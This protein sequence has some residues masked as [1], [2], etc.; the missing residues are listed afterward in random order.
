M[1]VL[2]VKELM[3]RHSL[4]WVLVPFVATV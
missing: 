3:L 2:F 4:L 1:R